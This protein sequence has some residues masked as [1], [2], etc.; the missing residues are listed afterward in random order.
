M[1]S[2]TLS[3]HLVAEPILRDV[4]KQTVCHLRI[5]V[6]NGRYPTTFIDVSAFG[7]QAYAC[8]EFLHKGRMVGVS[9]RLAY[10]EWSDETGGKRSSYNVIG[11]VEFLDR[12]SKP[13]RGSEEEL[14]A[15][16]LLEGAT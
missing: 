1:N 12:P 2:L 13:E 3:G 15:P 4:G 5:A 6:D 7:E 10:R 11:R 9:G 16:S 14:S 8:A